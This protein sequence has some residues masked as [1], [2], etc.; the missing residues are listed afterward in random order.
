MTEEFLEAFRDASLP[1]QMA[2]LRQHYGISQSELANALHVK[3]AY[4]SRLEHEEKDHLVSQYSQIA[5]TLRARLVFVP[6][7]TRLTK[8]SRQTT[9]DTARRPQNL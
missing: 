2:M 1:V 3:Q 9:R 7:G 4:F 8:R 5:T 6:F